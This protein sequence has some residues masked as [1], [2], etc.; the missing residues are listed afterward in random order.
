[1]TSLKVQRQEAATWAL[2]HVLEQ[3]IQW[4]FHCTILTQINK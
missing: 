1:M 3:Q 2:T 4:C